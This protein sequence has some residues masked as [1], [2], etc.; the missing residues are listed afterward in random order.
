MNQTISKYRS[1]LYCQH[2]LE[3]G[4]QIKSFFYP[5]R[6]T[7][8]KTWTH[9]HIVQ[10]NCST[11]DLQLFLEFMESAATRCGDDYGFKWHCKGVRKSLV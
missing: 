5:T 2:S 11:P 8:D 10:P 1:V 4:F 6:S 9:L 7:R 3:A